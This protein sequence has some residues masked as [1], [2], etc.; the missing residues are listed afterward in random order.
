MSHWAYDAQSVAER[1]FTGKSEQGYIQETNALLH[2]KTHMPSDVDLQ[3]VFIDAWSQQPWNIADEDQ[4]EAFERET[5][6]LW[7]FAKQNELFAFRT[8]ED[9]LGLN[10]KFSVT[11]LSI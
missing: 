4:Q 3:G 5:A 7:E 8:I 6:K 10:N 11:I 9:V 2:N 1:N